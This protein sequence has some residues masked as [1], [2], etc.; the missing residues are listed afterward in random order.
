M[1]AGAGAPTHGR[2]KFEVVPAQLPTVWLET[3]TSVSD[4]LYCL[5]KGSRR[6][7]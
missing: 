6:L 2:A 5:G 3:H 1:G 7:S 4:R